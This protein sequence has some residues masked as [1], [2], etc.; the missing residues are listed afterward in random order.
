MIENS[1]K[2]FRVVKGKKFI[3][4]TDAPEVFEI[5]A[6]IYIFRRALC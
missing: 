4:K 3:S 1:K 6:S 5:N 2:G